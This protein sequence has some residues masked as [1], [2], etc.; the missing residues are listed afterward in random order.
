M[1][2]PSKPSAAAAAAAAAP[3]RKLSAPPGS[4][5]LARLVQP[6]RESEVLLEGPLHIRGAATLGLPALFA[7][8][9]PWHERYFVLACQEGALTLRRYASE[10]E[11]EREGRAAPPR[12]VWQMLS[13]AGAA[14]RRP[15]LLRLEAVR[16]VRAAEPPRLHLEIAAAEGGGG[17]PGAWPWAEALGAAV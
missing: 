7:K 16:E 14:P 11:V 9:R 3:R 13:G 12:S 8:Q 5:P 4:V 15:R 6:L 2:T 1:S 17:G 10:A